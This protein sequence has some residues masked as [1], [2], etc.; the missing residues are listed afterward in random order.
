MA[1]EWVKAAIPEVKKPPYVIP[2]RYVNYWPRRVPLNLM[3]T[4]W[5]SFPHFKRF[6]YDY[7]LSGIRLNSAM[8]SVDELDKELELVKQFKDP[9]PLYFDFKARQL[10]VTKVETV[11][12]NLEIELNHEISVETPTVVLFKAGADVALLNKI[13]GKRLVFDGGPQWNVKPGESLHIRHPS[14]R[15]MGDIFTAAEKQKIEKVVKAG[16]SR[17]FLSYVEDWAEVEELRKW[18][19]ND[20]HLILKIESKKGLDFVATKFKDCPALM[21]NTNLM[22]ARGDLYV[23]VDKPHDILSA[24]RLIV[25]R[26]PKAYMGSRF[27]LSMVNNEVPELSDMADMAWCYDLGYRNMMLCDELCLKEELLSRAVNAMVAFKS[28]YASTY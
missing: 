15:V 11:G 8:I 21:A 5:P 24:L 23:E 6:A 14:L 26:D 20:A 25:K 7:R 1:D 4:L 3:V 12:P 22:A 13:D 19:G 27:L 28:T 10:R 9:V 16:F 17:Y 18:I 2:S